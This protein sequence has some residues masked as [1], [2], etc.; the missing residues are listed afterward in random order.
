MR[1]GLGL[2]ELMI[3]NPTSG[4]LSAVF[5]G[6]D[7]SMYGIEEMGGYGGETP[8]PR[9]FL[10]EGGGLLQ[11]AD[12]GAGDLAGDGTLPSQFFLGEDGT[13]YQVTSE[14]HR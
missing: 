13:L 5:L 10:G 3:V 8:G 1:P 7:G 2:D 6:H 9:Y 11:V 12:G 14:P 4:G